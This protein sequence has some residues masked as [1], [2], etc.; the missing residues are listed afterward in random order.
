[1]S[2][3]SDAQIGAGTTLAYRTKANV[4]VPIGTI[5]DLDGPSVTVGEVETTRL[6]STFKPYSPTI[7]EGEGSF[8]VQHNAGD[9]GVQA[10]RAMVSAPP[11]PIVTWI[12]TYADGYVD[13]FPGFSKGYQIQ[14]VEN[15]SVITATV[16][17]RMTGPVETTAPQGS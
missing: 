12:V 11:I 14:S 5:Q 3:N 9:P 16:P 17:I 1:M 15:E 7:P 10:L 6:S 13:E 2:A 4:T 8:T